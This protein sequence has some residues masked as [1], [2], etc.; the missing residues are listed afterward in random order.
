MDVIS[1]SEAVKASK[2]VQKLATKVDAATVA[3]AAKMIV[4]C[5]N[6]T[7]QFD[8]TTLILDGGGA[9]G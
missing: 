1:Y 2:A 8:G 3:A 6:A 4:D 7:S 5:G 9:N